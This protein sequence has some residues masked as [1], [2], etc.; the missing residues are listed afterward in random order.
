MWNNGGKMLKYLNLK[1]V[2]NSLS[3][4]KLEQWQLVIPDPP[5]ILCIQFEFCLI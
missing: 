4:T 3:T 5:E 2:Y 1:L